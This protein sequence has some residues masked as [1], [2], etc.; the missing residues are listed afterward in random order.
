MLCFLEI[1]GNPWQVS[2][3][4]GAYPSGVF[5]KFVPNDCKQEEMLKEMG[6]STID[7][8]FADIP[9]NLRIHELELPKGKTQ[10]DVETY[11]RTLEQK[12]KS[13][14]ETLCFLGGG[15]QH[16][17]IPALVQSITSRSEFYTAYTP[18]QPEAS[19]GFLQAMFEYQSMIASLMGMDIANASLYDGMTA[20]GEAALLC[21]RH[22][23]KNQFVISTLMTRLFVG[24]LSD[25]RHTQPKMPG[26]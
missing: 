24:R 13:S 6:M 9:K 20:L 18:Y 23:K 2:L 12:N 11:L 25:K 17:Y 16:H 3:R 7:E 5:M 14:F 19:Q 1:N 10:Q 26:N 8:L 15:I 22:T 21:H 4:G